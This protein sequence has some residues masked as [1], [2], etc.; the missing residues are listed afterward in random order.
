M[1]RLVANPENKL[2]FRIKSGDHWQIF[3][4]NPDWARFGR[5][6]PTLCIPVP[7]TFSLHWSHSYYISRY[8]SRYISFWTRIPV[9]TR[10]IPRSDRSNVSDFLTFVSR[11]GLDLAIS[12]RFPGYR[13]GRSQKAVGRC[14]FS[15]MVRPVGS[16]QLEP[17]IREISVGYESQ[18]GPTGILLCGCHTWGC[19]REVVY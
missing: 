14:R 9:G 17:N 11:V 5:T 8:I 7:V 12:D 13:I 2:K 19:N 6:G 1:A 10:S 15:I 18:S 4:L 16:V 3:Q